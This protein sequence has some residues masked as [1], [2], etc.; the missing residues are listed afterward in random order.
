MLHTIITGNVYCCTAAYLFTY[1]CLLLPIIC[2][3]LFC[4]QFL[5]RD[6]YFGNDMLLLYLA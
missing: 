6:F 3:A 1:C 2:I 4:G 5:Q